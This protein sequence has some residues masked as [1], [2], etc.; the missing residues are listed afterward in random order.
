[1][2]SL[3]NVIRFIQKDKQRYLPGHAVIHYHHRP[4]HQMGLLKVEIPLQWI[5]N[6][7]SMYDRLMG[8][9]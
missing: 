9:L 8:R 4:Q 6:N 5:R 7:P 3:G 2:T 1:M